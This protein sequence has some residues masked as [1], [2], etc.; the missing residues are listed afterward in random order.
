M[1]RTARP[2]V[3]LREVRHAM[4]NTE[5]DRSAGG[6]KATG[7]YNL[8]E[9]FWN[10]PTPA[11]YEHASGARGALSHLGAAGG[12]YRP[13]HRSF[14]QRQ[15][16]RRRGREPRPD[17]VGTINRP[18]PEQN[19]DIL[20][21]RMASY[22]QMK[23]VYV[24]DFA[25]ADPEY[26]MPIRIITEYAWHSLFA[27]NMFIQAGRRTGRPRTPIYFTVIDRATLPR[28]AEP[29]PH[30]Q[31]DLHPGQFPSA[32]GADR[33]H[34]L[35][36]EI[37]KSI[38]SVMNYLLPDRGVLPMHCSANIGSDGRT[39]LFSASA[40]TGKTT[41]FADK[42]RT[43]DRATTIMAGAITASSTSGLHC[44]DDQLVAGP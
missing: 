21:Q 41:L 13:P 7:L 16:H 1:T 33:R 17:L 4:F 20:H 22:L 6:W 29:G 38:F 24:Q 31:R 8:N 37:K 27:R 36:G 19:F 28:G 9:V 34:Q 18:I 5:P 25:S 3:V 11:L 43:L 15:V 32:A 23:D 30:A 42:A 2:L 12:A 35:R 14:G 26:R 40:G 44:Q 10:L 39:A